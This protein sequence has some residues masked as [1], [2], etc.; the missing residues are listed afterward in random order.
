MAH[1]HWLEHSSKTYLE[2]LSDPRE[3]FMTQACDDIPFAEILGKVLCRKT[4]VRGAS[5]TTPE[6]FFYCR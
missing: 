3:L 1:V 5:H 6:P 2:E 4:L